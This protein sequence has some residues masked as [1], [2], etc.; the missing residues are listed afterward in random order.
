[1]PALPLVIRKHTTEFGVQWKVTNQGVVI[2]VFRTGNAA[3]TWLHTEL[4]ALQQKQAEQAR[5]E[6]I[7]RILLAR[8]QQKTD[9]ELKGE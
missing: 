8:A 9:K 4:V 3:L 1:M 2:A 5:N 6:R 7:A